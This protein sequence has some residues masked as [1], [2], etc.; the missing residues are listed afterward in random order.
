MLC[1]IREC[2][3]ICKTKKTLNLLEKLKLIKASKPKTLKNLASQFGISAGAD[4]ILKRK[5][6]YETLVNLLGEH[7][8]IVNILLGSVTVHYRE[9]LLYI[10]RIVNIFLGSVTVH[11]REGLLYIPRIVNILLGSVTVHYREG[12]LYIPRIVNIWLGSVTVHYRER[13]LYIPV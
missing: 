10:P 13:L 12:L 3:N 8:R 1:G 5:R 11:Y 6:E 7:P 4:N 9:G 2:G